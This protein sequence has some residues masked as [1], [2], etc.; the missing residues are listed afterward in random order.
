MTGLQTSHDVVVGELV[1]AGA[2]APVP[3]G[4]VQVWSGQ[5]PRVAEA[6][7]D[8]LLAHASGSADTW[9]AY[10]TAIRLWLDHCATFN[11]DPMRATKADLDL[12]RRRFEQTPSAR[13]GTLP[14]PATVTARFNA[15]ASFYA[16]LLDEDLLDRSPVRR[17]T[18]PKAPTESSTVGLS[19]GEQV[20]L[21]ER[22]A[23]EDIL[24]RA[25][26][27]TLLL[28]GLRVSELL[29]LTVGRALR[30]NQGHPTM[31][32]IGKGGR[33]REI[34][35]DERVRVALAELV[36]DRYGD[37]PPVDAPVFVRDNLTVL[38]R[39]A[40][41]NRVRRICRAAGI[42]SWSRL[43]PHSLRHTSIT[44]MLNAGTPLN[45]VQ[46]FHGHASPTTTVRYDRDA[47]AFTRAA[48]A[49]D[50]RAEFIADQ[51]RARD[52]VQA[53]AHSRLH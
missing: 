44:Q 47:G 2:A 12:W 27:L 20:Q 25:V 33:S 21:E 17:R 22:C 29:G 32:V 14:K 40:V 24:D 50:R 16:F 53:D 13:Y 46:V 9:Q 31:E 6:V 7:R 36:A 3:A 8:W 23:V 48:R 35:V 37:D 19:A 28:Q 34:V 30:H 41:R 43:S 4:A 5:P 42:S 51:R 38:T 49:V 39:A 18:R 10:T 45:D 11:V 52:R 1:G 26:M 15:I